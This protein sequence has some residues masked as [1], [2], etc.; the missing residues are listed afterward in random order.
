MSGIHYV[1][2]V[3]VLTRGF[4]GREKRK[5]AKLAALLGFSTGTILICLIA[6]LSEFNFRCSQPVSHPIPAPVPELDIKKS[7]AHHQ[8]MD[9]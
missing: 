6:P 4:T 5:P 2:K 8:C 9:P 3:R 7:S 1:A